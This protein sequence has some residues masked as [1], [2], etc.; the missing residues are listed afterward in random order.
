L[1]QFFLVLMKKE[2]GDAPRGNRVAR[3]EQLLALFDAYQL[4]PDLRSQLGPVSLRTYYRWLSRKNP[5]R[6]RGRPPR[7]FRIPAD[8]KDYMIAL[9]GQKPHR[10]PVRIA[11]YVENK[12]GDAAV[13][14]ATVRRFVGWWQLEEKQLFQFMKDPD[15][16]KGR[17]MAAF[18]NAA[19]KAEYYLHA[20][21]FDHTPADVRCIDG[22]RYKVMAGIDVFSRKAW[23]LLSKHSKSVAVAALWRK[24]ITGDGGVFDVA[25]CDNGLEYRSRHIQAAASNLG[26]D[27]PTLPKFAPERKPHVERFLKTL[28]HGLFE[29]LDGFCGHCVAEGKALRNRKSFAERFMTEDEVIEVSLTSEQLQDKIDAW[30]RVVYNQRRHSGIGKSPEKK[31][32]ESKRP[33]RKLA[34]ERALDILLAPVCTAVVLKKGIKINRAWYQEVSLSLVIGKKVEVRFDLMDASRLYVFALENCE[35]WNGDAKKYEPCRPGDFICVARDASLEGLSVEEAREARKLQ[36]RQLKESHEAIKVLSSSLGDPMSDLLKAKARQ[37][38]RI[39]AFPRTIEV[40]LPAIDEAKR[41]AEE[42]GADRTRT[43]ESGGFGH[44]GQRYDWIVDHLLRKGE[45]NWTHADREWME[46]YKTTPEFGEWVADQKATS[47]EKIDEPVFDYCYERYLWLLKEEG[48]RE[49]TEREKAW[50]DRFEGSEEYVSA[51][52]LLHE[53]ARREQR[54]RGS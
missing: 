54:A 18:G 50:V 11:E 15:A 26:V 28:A 17:F 19:Q 10:R 36:R 34:D 3:L 20:I 40:D 12:F 35:R 41:A 8:Q 21:E 31:A 39:V 33:V 24:I 16:W 53:Y 29:E 23:V 43:H 1:V 51:A 46:W 37:P 38:G 9:L 47:T 49:L 32:S 44:D 27:L 6:K 48:L 22:L 30:I 52:D 2:L 4:A 25:I 42:A 7:G 45:E 5:S 13:S 14:E